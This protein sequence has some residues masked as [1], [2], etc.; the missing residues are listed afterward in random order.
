MFINKPP[1]TNYMLEV[2]RQAFDEIP[3]NVEEYHV[4]F[5]NHSLY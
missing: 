1:Q 2:K 4:K 5:L 3:Y